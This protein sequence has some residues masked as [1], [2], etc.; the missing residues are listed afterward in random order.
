MGRPQSYRSLRLAVRLTAACGVASMLGAVAVTS[1]SADL[2]S[3]TT[4][5]ASTLPAVPTVDTSSVLPSS[6]ALPSLAPLTVAAPLPTLTPLPSYSPLPIYSSVP[7]AGVCFVA[8]TAPAPA[9]KT[10][11]NPPNTESPLAIRPTVTSAANAAAGSGTSLDAFPEA[12]PLSGDAG[13]SAGI[14]GLHDTPPLPV[15][16]LSAVPGISFGQAPYLWPLFL[17]L[18]MAAAGAVVVVVRKT[19]SAT[20][21]D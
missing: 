11:T 20:A 4:T 2:V 7:I 14:G 9:P 1:V 6:S 17:L 13:S 12:V 21:A 16:T 5:V 18:D 15:Q 3:T 10:T 8:C 19:W